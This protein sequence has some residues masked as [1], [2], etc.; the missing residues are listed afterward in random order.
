MRWIGSIWISPSWVQVF[1]DAVLGRG[2]KLSMDGQG[3]WRDN[4][5]VERL[6]RSVKYERV[7]LRAY[8]S[9]SAARKDTAQY[10]DW[11]KDDRPHSSLN[12]RTPTEVWLACYQSRRL[13][14][15]R[16]SVCPALTAAAIVHGLSTDH[17]RRRGQRCTVLTHPVSLIHRGISVKINRATS[18]WEN[19]LYT[20]DYGRS[21]RHGSSHFLHCHID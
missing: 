16:S 12:D 10:M 9:V 13:P 8:D 19:Y 2:V 14:I 3:A 18:P 20:S 17:D 6:W 1:V 5:F 11:Y 15:M 7:Y 4:V 21:F